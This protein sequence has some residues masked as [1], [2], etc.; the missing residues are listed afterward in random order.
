MAIGSHPQLKM[1]E[2]G[3]R[4]AELFPGGCNSRKERKALIPETSFSD[5][6]SISTTLSSSTWA[7]HKCGRGNHRWPLRRLI[8][9]IPQ[10]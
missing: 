6:G 5:R 3:C 10:R 9:K 2:L 7:A 4:F 1:H 8:R